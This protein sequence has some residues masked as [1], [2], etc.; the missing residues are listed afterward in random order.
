ME[1]KKD[2]A[3]NHVTSVKTCINYKLFAV[4]W[5]IECT[6]NLKSNII[7]MNFFLGNFIIFFVLFNKF[8]IFR[9][10]FDGTKLHE[11]NSNDFKNIFI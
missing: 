2:A 1:K 6:N 7:Q 3:S 4:T 9:S 11:Q 8:I 5:N 10:E